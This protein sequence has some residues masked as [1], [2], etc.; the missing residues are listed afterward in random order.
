MNTCNARRC[1]HIAIRSAL[2]APHRPTR[3]DRRRVPD[4]RVCQV[5]TVAPAHLTAGALEALRI[6][7]PHP[8][9]SEKSI[10]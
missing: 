2:P 4:E 9:S 7:P 10:T 1:R 3:R 6:I 8:G 5:V